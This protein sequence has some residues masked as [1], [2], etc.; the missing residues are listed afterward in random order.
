MGFARVA[1]LSAIVA[2]LAL[3]FY[4]NIHHK[5]FHATHLLD[6]VDVDVGDTEADR[7]E[8][9]RLEKEI[10]TLRVQMEREQRELVQLLTRQRD[11]VAS[12]E[13]ESAPQRLQE[14]TRMQIQVNEKEREMARTHEEIDL[15]F[16]ELKPYHGVYSGM[17]AK[18]AAMS[19]GHLVIPYIQA[20][21]M[22]LFI[23][24]THPFLTV[25]IL[26]FFPA[27][28]FALSF[29]MYGLAF[30]ILPFASMVWAA[31]SAFRFPLLVLQY[32]PTPAEF[33]ICYALYLSVLIIFVRLCFA[34]S[35]TALS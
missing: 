2:L 16:L 31:V 4:E 3:F 11:V 24:F 6:D 18:D 30:S 25:F 12:A 19:L 10:H 21:S 17:F 7:R 28:L 29:I 9:Q 1:V 15:R 20:F 8:I 22:H 14:V 27:L 23:P 32:G 33:F 34:A 13:W 35:R 26:I 5:H